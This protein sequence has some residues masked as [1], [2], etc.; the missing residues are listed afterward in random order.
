MIR[1]RETLPPG[2]WICAGLI[3]LLTTGCGDSLSSLEMVQRSSRQVFSMDLSPDFGRRDD[4]QVTVEVTRIDAELN[5]LL[6]ESGVYPTEISFGEGTYILNF[7]T[8]D[9]ENMEIVIGISP[10]AQTGERYPVLTFSTVEG[11]VEARGTFFVLP[12]LPD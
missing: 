4:A 12:A 11:L 5:Q 1:H 6:A 9:S 2:V 3:V 10:L 7:R 8:N